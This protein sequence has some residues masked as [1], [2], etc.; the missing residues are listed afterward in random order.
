MQS[1][2]CRHAGNFPSLSHTQWFRFGIYKLKLEIKEEYSFQ[3]ALSFFNLSYVSP[4]LSFLSVF[5]QI[6]AVTFIGQR[7]R[8]HRPDVPLYMGTAKLLRFITKWSL[9]AA[10]YERQKETSKLWQLR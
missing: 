9:Q 3:V 1:F 8:W 7:R 4:S 5:N 2:L 6:P 10:I